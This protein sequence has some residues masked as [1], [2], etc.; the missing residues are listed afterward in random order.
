VLQGR[1]AYSNL[2]ASA[3]VRIRIH[4]LN[5]LRPISASWRR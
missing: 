5:I 2:E 4:D 1:P 3:Q